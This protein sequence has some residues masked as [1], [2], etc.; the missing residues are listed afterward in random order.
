MNSKILVLITIF[1]FFLTL[2]GCSDKMDKLPVLGTKNP[3]AKLIDPPSLALAPSKRS[4]RAA[5]AI[6]RYDG[7]RAADMKHYRLV[8]MSNG[9][10]QFY[11]EIKIGVHDESIETMRIGVKYLVYGRYEFD[12]VKQRNFIYVD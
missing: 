9:T 5:K 6:L 2:F 10:A 7:E 1:L 12:M 8:R 11:V 3:K 4:G